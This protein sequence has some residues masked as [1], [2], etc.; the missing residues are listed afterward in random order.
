MSCFRIFQPFILCL[1]IVLADFSPL[2]GQSE[3]LS[4]R[5]SISVDDSL[6]LQAC[7]VSTRSFYPSDLVRMDSAAQ[8]YLS[9]A[10]R[11]DDPAAIVDAYSLLGTAAMER[12]WD[13]RAMEAFLASYRIS[14]SLDLRRSFALATN[15][16][17]TIYY[18]LDKKKEAL[19]FYRQSMQACIEEKLT[20]QLSQIVYNVAIIFHDWAE[21]DSALKYYRLGLELAEAQRDTL[22]QSDLYNSMGVMTYQDGYKE[23]GRYFLQKSVDLAESQEAH[24][25]AFYPLLNLGTYSVVERRLS[26]AQRYL[27]QANLIAQEQE[28]I[29]MQADVA[30]A[31]AKLDSAR[32]DMASAYQHLLKWNMLTARIDSA[33]AEDDLAI[34]REKFDADLR[35]EQIEAMELLAIEKDGQLLLQTRLN[36]AFGFLLLSHMLLAVILFRVYRL[37]KK[38]NEVLQRMNA[39]K[40]AMLHVVAHDLQSPM[41]NIRGLTSLIGESAQLEPVEKQIISMIHRELD[42]SDAL[43]HNLLD[44]ESI[45]SGDLPIRLEP[46]N[47]SE[48]IAEMGDKYRRIAEPKR[49]K[50]ETAVPIADY[51]LR[52]DRDFVSRILD[53]LISNAIKFS[54]SDTIVRI[55]LGRDHK[56]L[57]IDVADR[58]PGFSELDKSRLFGRFQRLSAQPTA[59]ESS[60]G[61]GLAITKALVE[62]LDGRIEV[63]SQIGQGAHFSVYLPAK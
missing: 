49:I 30:R 36:W 12:G 59:G 19:L 1:C 34:L 10:T 62:R 56:E 41:V 17:G 47:L 15:N 45:E 27:S 22:A 53:N 61:L 28:A 50:V 32:G 52:T 2:Q 3:G 18:K 33:N 14:D 38:H 16:V 5:R 8:A 31:L 54:P 21:R 24:D 48:V 20:R 11:V 51:A 58:G 63:D 6:L 46:V 29:D 37:R 26:L 43:V 4:K 40:D 13:S 60:T 23:E 35:D 42:R 57:R 55:G 25:R 7:K 9:I 44:L 39:D